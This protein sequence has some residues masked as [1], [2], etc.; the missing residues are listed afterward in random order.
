MSVHDR[1]SELFVRIDP[2]F[3]AQFPSI[4]LVAY[5]YERMCRKVLNG[6]E[7]MKPPSK[8]GKVFLDSELRKALAF[9]VEKSI[10][11][12]EAPIEKTA[13]LSKEGELNEGSS[14]ED[15]GSD[16]EE[17]FCNEGEESGGDGEDALSSD[18]DGEESS[19]DKCVETCRGRDGFRASEFLDDEAEPD[20]EDDC[21]GMECLIDHGDCDA[22]DRLRSCLV[23]EG[24]VTG[25]AVEEEDVGEEVSQKILPVSDVAPGQ[26]DEYLFAMDEEVIAVGQRSSEFLSSEVEVVSDMKFDDVVRDGMEKRYHTGNYDLS[27][28]CCLNF[29]GIPRDC[30]QFCAMDKLKM[31]KFLSTW[32]TLLKYGAEQKK[33]HSV[34][35]VCGYAF[36]SVAFTY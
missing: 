22:C 36:D 9:T 25:S 26:L 35:C 5:E 18:G 29:V 6:L 30:V 2:V 1:P 32:Y 23:E 20:S 13:I 17:S 12:V 3:C 28:F 34:G 11:R 33:F 4:C 10:G 24:E 31:A 27:F 19:E 16:S 21:Y 7:R 15:N 14:V 8:A